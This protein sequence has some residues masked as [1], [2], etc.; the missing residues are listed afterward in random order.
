[1]LIFY[2]YK[3]NL[4]SESNDVIAKAG[5]SQTT[6]T[7]GKDK[8]K[9]QSPWFA[10]GGRKRTDSDGKDDK[11]TTTSKEQPETKTT[12]SNGKQQGDAGKGKRT[13]QKERSKT[14]TRAPNQHPHGRPRGNSA[15]QPF[16]TS[17][18]SASMNWRQA[19]KDGAEGKGAKNTGKEG[20][21]ESDE[22]EE[23]EEK[24]TDVGA[25][26]KP[27]LKEDTPNDLTGSLMEATKSK[28]SNS[29]EDDG[30]K[31]NGN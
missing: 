25:K 6:G 16:R 12:Q 23:R 9:R 26:R 4:V 18:G 27:D 28:R 5:L 1:M 22:K 29:A 2:V 14:Q 15:N 11:R 21:N 19:G 8:S 24:S 10:P 17:G 30:A 3:Q 7:A 20:E 13:E 31:A